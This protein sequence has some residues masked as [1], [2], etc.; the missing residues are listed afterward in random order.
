MYGDDRR[1]P[2]DAGYGPALRR[3]RTHTRRCLDLG[4]ERLAIVDP[5]ASQGPP[6][7]YSHPSASPSN[8]RVQQ[9][10]ILTITDRHDGQAD[11]GPHIS[12]ERGRPAQIGA[13]RSWARC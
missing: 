3:R 13:G 11:L 12:P 6:W 5:G 7:A 10:R 9:A 2:F 1:S 4:V 8:E